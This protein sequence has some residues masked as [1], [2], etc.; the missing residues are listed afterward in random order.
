MNYSVE[1][2]IRLKYQVSRYSQQILWAIL[3]FP[4]MNNLI[5][6]KPDLVPLKFGF[7]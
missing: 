6:T 5:S 2:N 7:Y 4:C 3:S 1:K